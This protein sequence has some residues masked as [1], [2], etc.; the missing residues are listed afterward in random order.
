MLT[1]VMIRLA[2]LKTEPS[3]PTLAGNFSTDVLAGGSAGGCSGRVPSCVETGDG[4]TVAVWGG[5]PDCGGVATG[6]V[7]PSGT[8]TLEL[9]LVP[10]SSTGVDDCSISASVSARWRAIS[11]AKPAA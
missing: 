5:N 7:P 6:A 11:S 9:G 1:T 8:G 10:I 4:S 2:S 3:P